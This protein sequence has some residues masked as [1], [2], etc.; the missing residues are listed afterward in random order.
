[1]EEQILTGLAAYRWA[2]WGWMA[3]VLLLTRA[4]LIHPPVAFVLVGLALAVTVWD[5]ALLRTDHRLLLRP[6]VTGAEVATGAALVAADGYVFAS[7]HVFSAAQSLGTAW[8]LAGIFMAAVAHGTWVGGAAGLLFG[9]MRAVAAYTNGVHTFRGSQVLSLAT[10]T[11]LYALAGG[12]S[13]HVVALLRRAE[14]EV[15][16]SR[17][18]EE[19]ARTLHDGVLQ[20]LAVIERRADPQLAQLAR[21][22]DR[23]LRSYLAG[24][25]PA[26][27]LRASLHSAASR[28]ESTFGGR[29][30]LAIPDDI[31]TP[32]ERKCEAVVGAVN[33]ALTNAG[34]HGHA[35]DVTVYI[36]PW[37]KGLFCTVR[38]DGYGFDVRNTPEGM[39]ISSSIRRRLEEVGGRVEIE[40]SAGNG[41]EVQMWIA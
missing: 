26:A 36:E 16:A 24:R 13:G 32:D 25:M 40:S 28:F 33:E 38:D 9:A 7:G 35:K 39:G 10:T 2:A 17:A 4:S 27:D 8:P 12:I 30:R 37:G 6:L 21:E 19:V 41:C 29:V 23:E 1:M 20:T 14:R 3:L 18:R 31:T 5:T 34:K 11:V 15:S 22:Q